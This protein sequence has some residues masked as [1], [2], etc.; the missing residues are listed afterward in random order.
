M[1]GNNGF[2]AQS[3][4]NNHSKT[5]C[6]KASKNSCKEDDDEKFVSVHCIVR[7]LSLLNEGMPLFALNMALA[8]RI[9]KTHGVNFCILFF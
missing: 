6:S 1:F 4:K 3:E 8:A 2:I 9:D 7:L 5:C